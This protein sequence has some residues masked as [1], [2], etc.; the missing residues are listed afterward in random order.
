MEKEMKDIKGE[1]VYLS[2]LQASNLELYLEVF[3]SASLYSSLYEKMPE[4]W[5]SMKEDIIQE[6]NETQ[7]YLIIDQESDNACGFIGVEYDDK[8]SPE[9]DVAILP[10]CRGKGYGYDASRVLCKVILNDDSVKC[11]LWHTF[12]SNSASCRIA[13]KL[14]GVIME[15]KDLFANIISEFGLDKN[16]S[17]FEDALKTITYEIKRMQRS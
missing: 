9:I 7:K 4:I 12:P 14:G 8:E 2:P 17:E 1:L 13:E 5:E 6:M 15:G 3:K 11:I 10:K 16:S